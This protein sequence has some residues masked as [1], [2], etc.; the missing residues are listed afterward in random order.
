[1]EPMQG[2]WASSRVDLG[3]TDLFCIEVTSVFF[4]SCESVPGDSL[5]FHQANLGSLCVLLGH[6]IALHAKQGIGP[7][8]AARGEVS[9]VFSSC[10]RNLGY[11]LELR[12]G[13]PF[14]TRV[15]SAKSGL[16]S[17]YDGQLRNLHYNWQDNTDASGT[18]VGD[19][20]SVSSWHN[21][22]GIAINFQE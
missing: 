8:L 4:S 16:L 11:I 13:R 3:Y 6:R 7:Q 12:W 5:E 9:W 14:E 22:I 10:G 18:E 20:A 21:D 17:C 15:H 2:K 1:M 19:Q